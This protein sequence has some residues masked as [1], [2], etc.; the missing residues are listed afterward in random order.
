MTAH[1]VVLSECW[2]WKLFKLRNPVPQT[3]LDEF[4]SF[5]NSP[6]GGRLA[7]KNAFDRIMLELALVELFSPSLPLI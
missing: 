7:V 3:W 2:L 4:E 6:I 5:W 1:R